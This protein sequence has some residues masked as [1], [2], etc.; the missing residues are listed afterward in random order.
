[1]SLVDLIGQSKIR[2]PSFFS[3]SEKSRNVAYWLG[4]SEIK[5]SSCRL[6]LLD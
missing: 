4:R 3:V 6:S 5:Y 1:M 2:E